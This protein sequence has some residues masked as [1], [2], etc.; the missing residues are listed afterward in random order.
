MARFE[1]PRGR[2]AGLPDWPFGSGRPRARF[3]VSAVFCSEIISHRSIS[4]APPAPAIDASP[5]DMKHEHYGN[6]SVAPTAT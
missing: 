5:T 4:F 6:F 1:E 3:A 2:P